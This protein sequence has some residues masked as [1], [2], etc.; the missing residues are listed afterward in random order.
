ME[1]ETLLFER[2]RTGQSRDRT[3][4]IWIFSPQKTAF[5]ASPIAIGVHVGTSKYTQKQGTPK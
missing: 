4:D 5:F 3:G 2:N 1:N